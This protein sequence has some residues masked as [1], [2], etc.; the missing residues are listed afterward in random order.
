[1]TIILFF[2]V[3]L[4][5]FFYLFYKL[6]VWISQKKIRINWALFIIG[7]FV[8]IKIIDS[9]FFTKMEFIQSKVYPN[10]YLVKN[11]ISD[12]DS[13]NAI[14]KEMVT[15]KMNYEFVNNE[16][17]YKSTYQ[18]TSDSPSRTYFNYSLRFYKYYKGWGTNPFGEAGTAHFIEHEED[19]GGFSSELLEYYEQ[20]RIAKLDIRFCENDTINYFGVLT[21][22]I[23]G[24]ETKTDTILNQ[25]KSK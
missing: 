5:L 9:V 24:E 17:K 14:I 13:L 10:L 1:M 7:I 21:F 6:I 15:Q 16:N 4:I 8:V 23:N 25:C 11:P 19:P 12:N 20:Y 18:F 22:F 2:S 3:I